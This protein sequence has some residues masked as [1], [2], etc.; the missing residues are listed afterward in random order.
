MNDTMG[1]IIRRL[2][3]ERGMTQEE[4][5]EILGVTFQ[6]VSKWENDTGI[7]DISQVVPLA[8]VFN[9]S[10]DMIFGMSSK[11][12]QKEVMK[13]LRNAQCCLS[14]PLNSKDLLKKYR[15]LQEGLKQ[16]PNDTI[17]LLQCLETGLSLSYPENDDLYDADNGQTIYQ[18]CIRYANLLI[19]YSGN[20]S[21]IMRAHMIMVMLHSAYGKF[22]EAYQHIEQFPVRADYNIHVMYKY[23]AHWRKE[24][25]KEIGSCQYANMHYI[26]AMLNN[27]TQL[28][29]AFL[30]TDQFKDAIKTLETE[31]A[32]IKCLFVDD[33]ILPPIHYREHGDLY[34][35]L[36]EAYLCDGNREMAVLNLKNMVDYDLIEYEK[37]KDTSETNS[38]LLRAKSHEFYIKR[39]DRYSQTA[40]KLKDKC[41]AE[42]YDDEIY[43]RLINR[44]NKQ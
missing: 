1:Q 2:R 14:R 10:T 26:E 16:Y 25:D 32:L 37:I 29:A 22:K 4:L 27:T 18:E 13:I 38:P 19:S 43:Q 3:L 41:F 35:L 12:N 9:V 20:T 17:L 21:D 28:A 40:V 31:L 7:P 36:A 11:N 33:D 6:A 23:F 34:M 44:V 15:I 30:K 24:Y 5:A 8:H 39:I 42:L